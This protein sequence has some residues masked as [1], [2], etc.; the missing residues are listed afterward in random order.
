M[1]V[2]RALR[3]PIAGEKNILE[4]ARRVLSIESAA[5]AALIDR[6]DSQFEEAVSTILRC[7]G[8]VIVTGIGKSGLIGKKIAATLS[9]TGTAAFFLHPADAVHG[10][11]G[12][13]KPEDVVICLSKSGNTDEISAL[14]PILKKIGVPIITFTGNLRSSL[15]ERS[16]IVIN[17]A[18]E[19]EACP[20]DLAPTASTTAMLAMGDALAVALLDQRGFDA[21]DFAFLHPAGSLG[22]RLQKIDDIM[23]TG[24]YLPLVARDT[25]MPDVI[26]EM[27]RKRFGGTCVIDE[28]GK[29]IGIITDGD[30]RRLLQQP[31]DLTSLHAGEV[32]NP[33]PKTVPLGSTALSAYEVM[34]QH[35]ILQLVIVDADFRPVG[36]VHLHDLLEAGIGGLKR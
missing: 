14:I 32:M 18:V 12:M 15:A 16:D 28:S 26:T 27:T 33:H 2:N 7:R 19:S 30:L 36:M 8:R 10:D 31:R 3:P 21:D 13:V 20:N 17:V 1:S 9:S 29:L 5:V 6:L 35:N 23:F 25:L 34:E 4:C 22:R 24:S 11:V